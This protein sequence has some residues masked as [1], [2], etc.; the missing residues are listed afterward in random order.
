MSN[1]GSDLS[2]EDE[3]LTAFDYVT[4]DSGNEDLPRGRQWHCG[5]FS[6]TISQFVGEPGTQNT[7]SLVARTPFDYFPLFFD[8][9]ITKRIVDETNGYYSQNPVSERQHMSNWQNMTSVEMYTFIAVTMLTGVIEKNRI[10]VYWNTDPLLITSIFGQYFTRNRY[11]D[12]LRFM[13]FANNEVISNTSRLEKIKPIID[14][15]KRKFPNCV[16]PAKNLC[17]DEPRV[18]ERE[19]WIQAVYPV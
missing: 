15:F 13:H 5:T 11:R 19:T 10:Q 8:E 3:L 17:V 9:T 16:N 2:S 18:M 14:D 4:I 7:I 1:S 6:P 12:I